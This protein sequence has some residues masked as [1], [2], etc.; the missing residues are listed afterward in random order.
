MGRKS[1]F[2]QPEIEKTRGGIASLVDGYCQR[3]LLLQVRGSKRGHRNIR[4]NFAEF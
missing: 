4:D 2:M 3:G 1:K